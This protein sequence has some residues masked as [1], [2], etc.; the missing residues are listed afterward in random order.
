MS[1]FDYQKPWIQFQYRILID[2]GDKYSVR[3][4]NIYSF[5][6]YGELPKLAYSSE[7]CIPAPDQS[8]KN[9][10]TE[11]KEETNKESEAF[12]EDYS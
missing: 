1:K 5:R 3:D 12:N 6:L 2:R 11:M 8:E 9:V 10:E 4:D 7:Q